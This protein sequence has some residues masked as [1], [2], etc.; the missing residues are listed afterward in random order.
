[1]TAAQFILAP[2][3]ALHIVDSLATG[4]RPHMAAGLACLLH[5]HLAIDA[6]LK[7]GLLAYVRLVRLRAALAGPGARLK[8]P[9]LQ[10]IGVVVDVAAAFAR[11]AAQFAHVALMRTSE[12]LHVPVA[13]FG[14]DVTALE[15]RVHQRGAQVVGG[16]VHVTWEL[17][18]VATFQCNGE[19]YLAWAAF[20]VTF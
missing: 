1:M 14:G 7:T 17:V 19:W 20:L 9:G 16:V 13:G 10:M 5:V 2:F 15:A 3:R 12:L 6:L 4:H 18:L 8:A 11:V